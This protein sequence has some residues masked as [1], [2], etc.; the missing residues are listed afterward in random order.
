M[1]YGGGYQQLFEIA[2]ALAK[3][4]PADPRRALLIADLR[5]RSVR[6]WIIED[7]K[8][9]VACV[10]IS[11]KLDEVEAVCDTITVIRDG[12]HVAPSR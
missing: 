6:C 12:K 4:A 7:L 5:A 10:Y 11:H 8:R 1:N 9:G 2:K 3:R